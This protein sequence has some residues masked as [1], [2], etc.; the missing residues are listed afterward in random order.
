MIA[1]LHRS[2]GVEHWTVNPLVVGSNPTDA[3]LGVYMIIDCISDLHGY[4][5]DLP[6]GDLLIIA[7]DMTANDKTKQWVRFFEWIQ[8]L[9]YKKIIYIGGNHDELLYHSC[10]SEEAR[11]MGEPPEFGHIEYLRDNFIIHEGLKIY[12]MPWT[13]T[14]REW[15]FMKDP[16]EPMISMVNQIPDDVDILITH[17][18][19]YGCL[20]QCESFFDPE[21]LEHAGCQDLR[22]RLSSLK[23][24][25]LH[26]FGHIHEGYGWR[27]GRHI[28][29]NAAIM[30][31]N[32]NPTN[33]PKRVILGET[34]EFQM[35]E[36]PTD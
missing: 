12:G 35:A 10:S 17:G 31:G 15:H 1:L 3:D 28:S 20:D 21:V 27:P 5:P 29:I 24:L 16:G 4:H 13:P 14:F 33:K 23:Q 18:P 32:Y 19:A 30:D 8:E 9:K 11:E 34:G 26:V 6:G 36:I 22:H 25:K 7:G 2:S